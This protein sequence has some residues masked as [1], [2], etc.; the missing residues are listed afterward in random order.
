M[1]DYLS[2]VLYLNCKQITLLVFFLFLTCVPFLKK[3]LLVIR[4]KVCWFHKHISICY[5][6]FFICRLDTCFAVTDYRVLIQWKVF[7]FLE[8]STCTLLMVLLCWSLE[9]LE[10]L[11]AYL[12]TPMILYFH[13]KGPFLLQSGSVQNLIM[14]ISGN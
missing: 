4:Q 8:K 2:K 14:T 10:I 5:I 13:L 11:N 9:K 12:Q 6:I 1:I 7:F 3:I